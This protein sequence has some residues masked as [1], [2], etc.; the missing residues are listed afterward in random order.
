M[1]IFE[2]DLICKHMEHYI[3]VQMMGLCTAL[4]LVKIASHKCNHPAAAALICYITLQSKEL[5]LGNVQC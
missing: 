5:Q 1:D 2:L 3:V 4:M